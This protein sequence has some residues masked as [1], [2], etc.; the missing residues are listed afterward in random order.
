L[1]GSSIFLIALS[2]LYATLGSVNMIHLAKITQNLDPDSVAM[3]KVAGF[4]LLTVFGLKSAV[5]P[6]HSWLPT[7]YAA[8]SSAVSALFAIMSKVGFYAIL[9][10]WTILF[11]ENSG[12]LTHFGY[13][14]LWY[15]SIATIVVGSFGALS[16]K[17]LR[18]MLGYLVITSIGTV[19]ASLSVNTENSMTAALVYMVHSTWIMGALYMITGVVVAQ[20]GPAG[21]EI[22]VGHSLEQPKLLGSLFFLSAIAVIGLPPFSGFIGKMV[23]LTSVLDSSFQTPLWSV[24]LVSSFLLLVTLSRAGSHLFWR[25]SI[26]PAHAETVPQATKT[27]V[28]AILILILASQCVVIFANFTIAYMRATSHQ[29]LSIDNYLPLVN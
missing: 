7:T 29:L 21:D 13:Q 23:I 22:F 6:F 18:P 4:L 3:V 19:L 11:G 26:F 12:E 15:M 8:A 10:I 16:S 17:K 2:I 27:C 20:R 1:V 5:V 9:R 25:S 14:L 28:L 24:L